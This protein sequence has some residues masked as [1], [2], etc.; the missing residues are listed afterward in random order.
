MIRDA[1][2]RGLVLAATKP[3]IRKVAIPAM[4][5]GV[6]GHLTASQA[7]AAIISGIGMAAD[8]GAKFDQIILPVYR[9][10]DLLSEYKK[11]MADG[12]YTK[13]YPGAELSPEAGHFHYAYEDGQS[14]S[15]GIR[16]TNLGNIK[17]VDVRE[18]EPYKIGGYVHVMPSRLADIDEG[19]TQLSA[20]VFLKTVRT[21][22]PQY[23]SG[24]REEHT[25][26][27]NTDHYVGSPLSDEQAVELMIYDV[28]KAAEGKEGLNSIAFSLDKAFL[29]LPAA[30]SQRLQSIATGF[31]NAIHRLREEKVKVYRITLT[32]K[33][34]MKSA[35]QTF[36]RTMDQYA[37][38][39]LE[40]YGEALDFN[41]GCP[42]RL[43]P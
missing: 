32:V 20:T 11:L 23:R 36:K 10:L 14:F 3:E 13:Y 7:A 6:S 31:M 38:D 2:Y 1:V 37:K 8:Q 27:L 5:T 30:D 17:D 39:N 34:G 25:L 29:R 22:N 4:G 40:L 9:E 12:S 28:V 35:L 33:P 19:A 16:L 18:W 21:P 24:Y 42:G 43:S 15:A 26:L 41:P